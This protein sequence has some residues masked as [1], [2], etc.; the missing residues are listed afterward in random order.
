MRDIPRATHRKAA[1]IASE[2]DENL[3]DIYDVLLG[4]ITTP[5]SFVSSV[6]ACSASYDDEILAHE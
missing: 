5:S 2:L 6:E 3:D 4:N 1:W